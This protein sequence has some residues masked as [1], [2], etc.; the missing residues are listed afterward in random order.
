[1]TLRA[2]TDPIPR[3]KL[4]PA[5]QQLAAVLLAALHSCDQKT[6][7]ADL[8]EALSLECSITRHYCRN[9]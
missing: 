1:M 3:L 4:S 9:N 2:A 7:D 6:T 8:L 5:D